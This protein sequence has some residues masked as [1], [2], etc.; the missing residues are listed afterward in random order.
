V[1]KKLMVSSETETKI[2]TA[3]EEYRPVA[4]RGSILY[5]LIV[6]LSKVNVMYQTALRQF[7]VLF[8][9][10]IAKSK[11]THIINVPSFGQARSVA[12]RGEK[13][14]DIILFHPGGEKSKQVEVILFD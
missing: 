5:F 11:P 7:L 3:R 8:D 14:K 6:E 4:T 10:S 2:N 1:S 9:G 12:L 13:H